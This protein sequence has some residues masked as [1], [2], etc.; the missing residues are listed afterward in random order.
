[1]ENKDAP[2][3]TAM[4]QEISENIIIEQDS[5]KYNLHISSIGENITFNLEYDSNNYVKK[6]SLKE[7]KDKE[8]NAIFSSHSIKDFM[9]FLKSVAQ[10]KKFSV[11]KMEKNIV[12]N[13]EAPILFKVHIK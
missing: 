10:M 2:I 3:P 8:S 12:I 4:N 11:I 1:M 7:I 9:E 5:A 6:T 13:F